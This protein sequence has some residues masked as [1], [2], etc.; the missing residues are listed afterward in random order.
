MRGVAQS[1]DYHPEGDVLTHTLLLLDQ[2]PAG[3]PETLALGALLHDVGK[4]LCVGGRTAASPSTA[5]RPSAPR[6][7]S[8]SASACGGAARRGSASTT[9]C[10]TTSVWSRRPRCGSRR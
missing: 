7:P 8:P 1:P 6:W 9:S 3:A 4:P 2:L 10:G 5:T